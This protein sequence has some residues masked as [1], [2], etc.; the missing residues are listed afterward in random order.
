MWDAANGKRLFDIKQEGLAVAQFSPDGKQILPVADRRDAVLWDALSGQRL[1]PLASSYAQ[2]R[3]AS[4][5]ISA[6]FSP[7]GNRVALVDWHPAVCDVATGKA[8]FD[9]KGHPKQVRDID[10]SPDGQ[11]LVTASEDH[12][13]RIWRAAAGRSVAVPPHEAKVTMAMFSP[14]AVSQQ[15]PG[16]M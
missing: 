3:G 5:L 4:L 10:Y 9:L 15:W 1:R 2:L 13:A 16:E 7:D 8:L 11:R 12:T 14:G 6:S